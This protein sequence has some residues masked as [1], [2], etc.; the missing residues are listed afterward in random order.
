[1]NPNWIVSLALAAGGIWVGYRVG[2]RVCE[3][4]NN[5]FGIIGL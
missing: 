4:K 5:P 2:R 1:M 3:I